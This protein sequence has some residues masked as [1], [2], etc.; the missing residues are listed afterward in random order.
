[1]KLKE[2]LG[3]NMFT[4]A[5]QSNQSTASLNNA[6]LHSLVLSDALLQMK[7]IQTDKHNLVSLL[8]S[9]YKNND[10]QLSNIRD[11]ANNYSAHK[12][13][14]WYTRD[15]FLNK[16]L[17]KTLQVQNFDLLF[18]L[19]F[20]I[21]DIYRQLKQNQCQS[22]V[23]AYRGQLMTNDELDIFQ[24]SKGNFLSNNSFLSTT[25]CR[26]KVLKSL[27]NSNDLHRVLFV[28]DADPRLVQS[29]PFAN[30]RYFSKSADEYE[31]LFMIGCIFRLVDIH[32]DKYDDQIW[33]IQAELCDEND[34][35]LKTA[36]DSMKKP[37]G[38]FNLLSFGDI[39]SD[40]NKYD[41]AEKIYHRLLTELSSNDPTLADLYYSF[42]LL[43]YNKKDYNSSLHW[44][45]K[46][47]KIKMKAN[48]SNYFGIG[49][50][51]HWI[52]RAYRMKGDFNKALIYCNN[53]VELYQQRCAERHP[54]MAGVYRDIADIYY[55]QNKYSEAVEFYQKSLYINERHSSSDNSD[56]VDIHNAIGIAYS[57][58]E[59][60]T[61]A[62]ECHRDALKIQLKSYSPNHPSV[63]KTY[64]CI[65]IVHEKKNELELALTYFRKAAAIYRLSLPS[66]HPD[67]I[68]IE[69]NIQ[70]VL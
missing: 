35:L 14:W 17:N 67:V 69:K 50:V 52:G 22:S 24:Q 13:V 60:Y 44:F 19:R 5:D 53:V 46:A 6:F 56:V 9:E 66:E 21:N 37:Y 45:K 42:G 33:I 7:S 20:V 10:T 11:F 31:V 57:H 30:T 36:F 65:G 23:R 63:A 58:L 16:I 59:Q 27:N 41:L 4:V 40:M 38:Q 68:E 25:T 43:N 26:R 49:N 32:Q 62:M 15:C 34:Q 48:P 12:A 29:K 51:N 28:I 18:S 47:V 2:P 39:L 64:R 8:I 3:L 1:M 61:R 55:K 70:R 54:D